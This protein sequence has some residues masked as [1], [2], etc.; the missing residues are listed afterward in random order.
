MFQK[1]KDTVNNLNVDKLQR[2]AKVE[3][4]RAK[5]R[6]SKLQQDLSKQF[7]Q[8]LKNPTFQS[9]W[10]QAQNYRKS[11]DPKSMNTEFIKRRMN[12]ADSR[13]TEVRDKVTDGIDSGLRA[14]GKLAKTAY[15]KVDIPKV[16][17][18]TADTGKGLASDVKSFFQENYRMSKDHV[19]D[20]FSGNKRFFDYYKRKI[21]AVSP[22]TKR[23]A[24][25]FVFACVFLYGVGT[26]LPGAIVRYQIWEQKK[27][28]KAANAVSSNTQKVDT[29]SRSLP[30][31]NAQKGKEVK[32]V[33]IDT[34]EGS[35]SR[36]DDEGF[37]VQPAQPS[38]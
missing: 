26:G 13:W 33:G 37:L 5:Y 15:S 23:K 6:A 38:R 28:M 32:S 17:E 12:T 31:A 30:L 10:T 20:Y 25:G 24:V 1:L 8:Q 16:V 29:T 18:K 27:K 14:V 34:S 9:Y 19:R 4:N 35:D 7:Q 36:Y 2:D 11:F 21:F 3:L 22:K